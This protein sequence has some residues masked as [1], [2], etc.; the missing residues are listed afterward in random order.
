M[1]MLL[2]GMLQ[3]DLTPFLALLWI[4]SPLKSANKFFQAR[5]K[6]D[7]N[8]PKHLGMFVRAWVLRILC[9]AKK[10][11]RNFVTTL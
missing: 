7:Q 2:I 6:R 11:V 9:G 4:K 3:N 5:T 10:G 1:L 8:T